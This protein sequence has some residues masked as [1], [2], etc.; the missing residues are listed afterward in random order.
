MTRLEFPSKIKDQA[1]FRAAGH[2]Q[3]CRLPFGG[4]KPEFDHIL[5]ASLGGLPILANC[6]VICQPCHKRKTSNEDVPRIRKADRQ[7]RA[8]NG[9][10]D[11]PR[12]KIKSRNFPQRDRPE[13]KPS[14]QPRALYR[15]CNGERE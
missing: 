3:I 8:D 12:V 15:D 10:R 9:A 6:A 4:K 7:R 5:P 11:A 13:P 1:A 2:C 14:L